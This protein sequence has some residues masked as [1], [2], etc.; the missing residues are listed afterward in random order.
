MSAQPKFVDNSPAATELRKLHDQVFN[1]AISKQ[2]ENNV[3]QFASEGKYSFF[4]V[5]MYRTLQA[6]A[7]ATRS[8][9]RPGS[10]A[11]KQYDKMQKAYFYLYHILE[12]VN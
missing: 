3:R 4:E 10:E 11:Y 8:K 7:I 6:N 9:Y 5:R 1:G 2:T 12:D